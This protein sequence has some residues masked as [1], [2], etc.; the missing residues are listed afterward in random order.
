MVVH[1]QIPLHIYAVEAA[2]DE[3]AT[4]APCGASMS[5][6]SAYS[7][8]AKHPWR[9]VECVHETCVATRNIGTESYFSGVF[10]LLKPQLG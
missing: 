2:C 3:Y 7:A 4:R 5:R 9:A 8:H 6:H 10:T 1:S